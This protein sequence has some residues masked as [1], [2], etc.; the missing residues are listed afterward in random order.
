VVQSKRS[1]ERADVAILVL[2][3]VEGL[4]DMDATIAGYA[5]KAGRG[6]VIAVNKWDLARDR[7]VRQKDF[8]AEVRDSLKFLDYAP[9]VFVS[10]RT[11]EGIGRLLATADRVGEACRMRVTT[12]QL[13]RVVAS[14]ARAYAPKAAKG[15]APVSI[16][17]ASQIGTAP[18][19]FVISLS[20]PVDLHFS[21]KRY[22]QNK[23]RAEF[24]FEGAPVFL[25]VRTRRH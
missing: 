5:E 9:V 16:L 1:L 18:P 22:L 10:A 13:N 20:H 25:K 24:G 23:I 12:G 19:T 15:A 17:F 2:D 4:R 8:L 21:Y 7:G 14:A 3:A 11:G 6:V